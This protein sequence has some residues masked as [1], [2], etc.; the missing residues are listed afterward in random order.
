VVAA[1]GAG[2]AAAAGAFGAE[3]LPHGGLHST[4]VRLFPAI[5]SYQPPAL[6][7]AT[8]GA[9]P[10]RQYVSCAPCHCIC[11]QPTMLRLHYGA[12]CRCLTVWHGRVLRKQQ[13]WGLLQQGL[14]MSKQLAAQTA[15]RG[16]HQVRLHVSMEPTLVMLVC[17][18]RRLESLGAAFPLGGRQYKLAFCTAS[19]Q[20]GLHASLHWLVRS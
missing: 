4:Q 6:I 1:V 7:R 8:Q 16:W 13:L 14:L 17:C 5:G 15:F 19:D 18:Q 9:C 2:Q 10:C 3:L 11:H 12:V 20:V